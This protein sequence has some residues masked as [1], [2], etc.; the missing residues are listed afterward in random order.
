MNGIG[1]FTQSS[2]DLVV[3]A[4]PDQDDAVILARISNHFEMNFRDQRARR[5]D[6]VQLPAV[7]FTANFRAYAM[8]TENRDRTIRNFVETLH[9]NSSAGSEILDDK[10]VVND[11]LANVDRTAKL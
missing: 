11:F 1:R 6:D 7:R 10:S 2:N 8:G 5:V 4:M 3:A 9:K